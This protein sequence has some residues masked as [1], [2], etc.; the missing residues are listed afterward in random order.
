MPAVS[1]RALIVSI[2]AAIAL[3]ALLYDVLE[4]ED[5]V[6]IRRGAT[7]PDLDGEIEFDSNLI[8]VARRLSR[9]RFATVLVHE[10]VHAHRGGAKPSKEDHEEHQVDKETARLLIPRHA[11]P[12]DLHHADPHMIAAQ[13]GVDIDT[14]TQAIELARHPKTGTEEVA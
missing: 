3:S 1:I 12:P 14:A 11:L 10:L 7:H 5:S 8:T 4:H 6:T 2:R 13:L 9:D